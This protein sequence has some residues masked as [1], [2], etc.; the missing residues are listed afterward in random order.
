MFLRLTYSYTYCIIVASNV[1]I[2]HSISAHR[3]EGRQSNRFFGR[4]AFLSP[5]LFLQFNRHSVGEN[6]VFPQV[7]AQIMC[8]NKFYKCRKPVGADII[9]PSCFS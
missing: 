6:R 9:R 3:Y 7:K 2:A 8:K 1:A 4:K 5:F